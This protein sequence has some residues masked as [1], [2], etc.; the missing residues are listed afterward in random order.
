LS[1]D[2]AKWVVGIHGGPDATTLYGSS[3]TTK[4]GFVAGLHFQYKLDANFSLCAEIN[5]E[6]KG[7]IIDFT[8]IEIK[9]A[10]NYAILPLT[11]R[12]T[13]NCKRL[14]YFF[15]LGP[16]VG[17]LIKAI[18]H[19]SENGASKRTHSL[20]IENYERYDFGVTG[21]LGTIIPLSK[22][23]QLPIEVRGNL[24]LNQIYS[25]ERYSDSDIKNESLAL[26]IG[27]QY[28]F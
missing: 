9:E 11:F 21:G 18:D 16:Y 12:Y 27:L 28:I 10:L 6:M 17:Y 26:L 25:K 3:V 4:A 13:L 23:F 1:Q 24:G 7:Y 2:S 5:Y 15:Q 19:V 20:D 22:K 8:N 14:K